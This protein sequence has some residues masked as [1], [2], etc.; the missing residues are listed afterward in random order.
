L[1]KN[2]AF[3]ATTLL[4]GLLVAI[5]VIA[6]LELRRFSPSAPQQRILS[7]IE[8]WNQAVTFARDRI[9]ETDRIRFPVY[10]PAFVRQTS[11]GTWEIDAPVDLLDADGL[12]AGRKR[13]RAVERWEEGKGWTLLEF[14]LDL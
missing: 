4:F 3:C 11:P 7:G 2:R 5:A 9:G 1:R 10:S 6:F 14:S 8:A 12:P 13:F